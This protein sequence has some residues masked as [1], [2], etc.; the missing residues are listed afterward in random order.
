MRDEAVP[1]A[2]YVD[3]GVGAEQPLVERGDDV[4]ILVRCQDVAQVLV[5]ELLA[6]RDQQGVVRH[7]AGGIDQRAFAVGDDE[8]LVGLHGV[9]FGVVDEDE[10]IRIS[11]VCSKL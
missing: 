10:E 9:A 7:V 11:V 1:Q 4:W 3:L 6:H 5:R 8:E 2:R